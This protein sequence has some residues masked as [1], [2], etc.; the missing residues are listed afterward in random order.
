MNW[1]ALFRGPRKLSFFVIALFVALIFAIFLRPRSDKLVS[2]VY[3][4][5]ETGSILSKT[6][7]LTFVSVRLDNGTLATIEFPAGAQLRRGARVK[8]G[9]YSVSG[10]RPQDRILKFEGYADASP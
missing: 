10:G 7:R 8:I 9:V 6:E 2:Y 3:G 1:R 4:V 5:E